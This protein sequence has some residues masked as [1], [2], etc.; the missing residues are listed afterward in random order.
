MAPGQTIISAD[1]DNNFIILSTWQV[2][3]E[4]L[5]SQINGVNNIFTT[6]S[7]FVV[8]S[9]QVFVDGLLQRPGTNYSVS[10]SQTFQFISQIPVSG[11]DILCSYLKIL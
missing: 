9:L 4:D 1:L 8:G 10:G 11:Q 6:N 5:T 2:F 7:P 3:N